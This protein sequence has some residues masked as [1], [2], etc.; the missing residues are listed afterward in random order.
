VPPQSEEAKAAAAAVVAY[1]PPAPTPP[2]VV[3]EA[4]APPRPASYA[5]TS[6][7]LTTSKLPAAIVAQLNEL[8]LLDPTVLPREDQ[9][10]VIGVASVGALALFLLP[11]FEIGFFGD[12]VVSALVGGGA[13]S[14]FA[15][16]KDGVG[17]QTRR[18]VG[19]SAV[20]AA[21]FAQQYE[22]EL[23]L[24]ERAKVSAVELWREAQK[25]LL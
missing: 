16:R 4:V 11:L 25:K 2:A 13:A 15:L 18:V 9:D 7:A 6:S 21:Y 22:R 8:E 17:S 3:A 14:Y 24:T 12:L 10:H 20:L 19:K 23:K 5:A 1:P